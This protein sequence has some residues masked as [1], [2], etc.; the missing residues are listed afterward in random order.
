MITT[1]FLKSVLG[2]L[3][4]YCIV[5]IKGSRRVQTFYSAIDSAIQAAIKAD[6][7]GFDA[8]YGLATFKTDESRTNANVEQMRSFFL[9]LDCGETKDYPTQQA[10]LDDLRR[11]CKELSL[12]RPTLV[13]SGR[14]IHVYW[15]LTEPVSRETW[16]PVAERLKALCKEHNLM[17]DPVVTADSAR[18]LRVPG[19]H[20]YKDTPPKSVEVVGHLSAHVDFEAFKAILGEDIF[21]EAQKFTPRESSSVMDALSGNHA[22]RFKTIMIKS[23]N[24]TGCQQLLNAYT[25]QEEVSEP[26]WR[27]ALS[28]AKFCVD[29]PMAVHKLSEK[30]PDYTAEATEAKVDLI[31]GPYKCTRFD[32]YSGGICPECPHWAR[33]KT[34]PNQSPIFLGHE[35]VEATEEDNMVE[36][37]IEPSDPNDPDEPDVVRKA[38]VHIPTYPAPYFRGKNGGVYRRHR[39]E[40]GDIEQLVYH[41]DIYVVRRV[42]DPEIG[43][44]VIL[45]LHLPHDGVREFTV[46]LTA[47]ASKDEFKRQLAMHGVAMLKMDDLMAYITQW[48]NDLQMKTVAQEAHR[49]FG[50]TKGM[51][52]FVLGDKEYFKD[53]WVEN[54]PTKATRKLYGAFTPK[55]TLE[56]WKE[57]AEFYNRPG[58]EMHQYVLCSALGS[59]L[60]EYTPIHGVNLHI[61]SKDSG[62]GKTTAMMAGLSIWGDPEQ[63]MNKESD[64]FASKMNRAE[65]LKNLPFFNDEMT[66]AHPKDLSDFAYMLH[67]GKQ[68]NRMSGNGNEERMRGEPWRLLGVSSGNTG[69][70]ERIALWKALP[71]A[72]AQRILEHQA[73]KIHF[74]TKE[75]TDRFSESIPM[76]VGHVGPM[77]VQYIMRNHEGVGQLLDKVQQITDKEA[78]LVA[79]NRFW[80][81][82]MAC[83]L[84]AGTL[85][86]KMGL[87][88]YDMKALREWAVN[89]AKAGKVTVREMNEDPVATI[90]D[91]L[92]ENVNNVLRLKSTDD[93]RKQDNGLDPMPDAM[94]RGNL[95]ARVETDVHKIY[96][97]LKPLREWCGKQQI[98]YAALIEGLKAAPMNAKKIKTRITKGTKINMPPVD[99]IVIDGN[100]D[101]L[102]GNEPVPEEADGS[103]EA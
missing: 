17:A 10:A 76:N 22:S 69:M 14:G 97:M 77:F 47:I 36:V 53:H 40:E 78:G 42:R 45:N 92:A 85:A 80:S 13:N 73:K 4:H 35:I 72:E 99:V 41:N 12:P 48:V 86:K 96:F 52:S 102:T 82:H 33:L 7:D 62:L 94:P 49:Q 2:E 6:A 61:H 43:E 95:V 64:T 11:F 74:E 67:S 58:F 88:N 90:G 54:Y 79:E 23:V 37:V 16:L 65:V 59:V 27:A 15:P 31:K 70:L 32:E 71:K 89:M 9:D 25:K 30:H 20:N 26:I 18:I 84:S 34:H 91:Y 68:R 66:N 19:T 83:T 63:L 28:I 24:G 8:Y 55:G 57:M 60:M 38:I 101:R 98:N 29:G 50:W 39:T 75:E 5:A 87:I 93:L 3:G 44:A 46:P 100:F 1:N 81:V 51:K 21:A 103:D 56:G